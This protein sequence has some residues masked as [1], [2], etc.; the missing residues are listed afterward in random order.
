MELDLQALLA[1]ARRAKPAPLFAWWYPPPREPLPPVWEILRE[2]PE[3]AIRRDRVTATFSWTEA[4]FVAAVSPDVVI[5]LIERLFA[6]SALAVGGLNEPKA[7]T[8]ED[9]L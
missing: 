2:P 1:T 5:E 8:M 7:E 9:A 6:I 4:D 3:A